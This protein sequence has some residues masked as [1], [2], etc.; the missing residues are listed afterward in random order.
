[1][2]YRVLGCYKWYMDPSHLDKGCSTVTGPLEHINTHSDMLKK[3]KKC[4][5]GYFFFSFLAFLRCMY[6]KTTMLDNMIRDVLLYNELLDTI[7]GVLS[8]PDTFSAYWAH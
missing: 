3:L 5:Y 2:Q 6:A 7:Q 8:I 1:M 4:I